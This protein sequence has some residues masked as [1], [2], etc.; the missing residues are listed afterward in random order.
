[1]AHYRQYL[2]GSARI[3]GNVFCGKL[4]D[5]A[6]AVTTITTEDDASYTAAQLLAGLI[7]RDPNGAD[8]ADTLPTA[9]ALVAALPGVVAGSTFDFTIRNLTDAQAGET[10]TVTAPD[11]S[12]TISGVATVELGKSRQFRVRFDNV[13]AGAEAYTAYSLGTL[14]L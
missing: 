6:D 5:G 2:R 9:A 10:I 13:T 8:R 11:A 4:L 7:D 3:T 1:M 12:V 14:D